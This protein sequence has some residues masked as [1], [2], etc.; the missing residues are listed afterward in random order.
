M[1]KALLILWFAILAAAIV[2]GLFSCNPQR[3]IDKAVVTVLNDHN[4]FHKVASIAQ[5]SFPCEPD[6]VRIGKTIT[7]THTIIDSSKVKSLQA[8]LDSIAFTLKS[9]CKELN[10]DSLIELI[11]D[12][13]PTPKK[14][15]QQVFRTDTIPDNRAINRWK[16]SANAVSGRLLVMTINRDT[17][18]AGSL[19]TGQSFKWFISA[20]WKSIKWWVI[21]AILLFAGYQAFKLFNINPLSLL[22]SFK[23]FLKK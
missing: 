2:H 22:S 8:K 16:D 7:T 11:K 14:E 9:K 1:K 3:K 12:S 13:L 15:I 20:L 23:N 4:A 6:T 21:V 10:V 17:L 18:Q 5:D 19:N